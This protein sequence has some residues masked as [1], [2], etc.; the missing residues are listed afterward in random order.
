M[1]FCRF[2]F[3]V[4]PMVPG[5]EP[6]ANLWSVLMA[7]LGLHVKLSSSWA[8]FVFS[9]L[10][11]SHSHLGLVRADLGESEPIEADVGRSEPIWVTPS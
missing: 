11:V 2:G 4:F 7:G 10:T 8:M 1:S 5:F 6:L 9:L 3:L